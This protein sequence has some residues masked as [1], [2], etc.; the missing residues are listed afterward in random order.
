MVAG[1]W[2]SVVVNVAMGDIIENHCVADPN[3]FVLFCFVL[4]VMS[5]KFRHCSADPQFL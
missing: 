2:K 5:V 3:N 4:R 1:R